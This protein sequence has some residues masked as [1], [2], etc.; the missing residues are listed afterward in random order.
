MLSR[1]YRYATITFVGGGFGDDG[2]HNVLEAAVYGKPVLFGPVFNQF[3]EAIDLL[4]EG[5]AFTVDNALDLEKTFNDLLTDNELYRECCEAAHDYDYKHKG[6]TEKI[7]GYI[8][9]NRLLM[10]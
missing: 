6:A 2:V 5:A 3:R 10:S 1:L 4:E 9:E 8:Q 7:V